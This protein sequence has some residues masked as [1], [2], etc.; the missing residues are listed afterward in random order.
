MK[1]RNFK[2]IIP[3]EFSDDPEEIVRRLAEVLNDPIEEVV[4]A[5]QGRLGVENSNADRIEFECPHNTPVD[6]HYNVQG[7]RVD[8]VQI[9]WS[10]SAI[11]AWTWDTVA[12]RTIRLT[13]SFVGAPS[14]AQTLRILVRG[15]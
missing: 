14:T 13:V 15:R 1:V 3:G 6:V 5:L 7:D 2:R 9:M 10:S 4:L 12:E 8:E 11:F